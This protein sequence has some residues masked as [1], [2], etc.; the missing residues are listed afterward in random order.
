MVIEKNL[1]EM[2]RKTK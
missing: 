1:V 2:S